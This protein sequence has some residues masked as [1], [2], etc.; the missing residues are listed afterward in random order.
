MIEI[1]EFKMFKMMNDLIKFIRINNIDKFSLI[2][3]SKL[4]IKN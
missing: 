1:S 4:F 3:W 2:R